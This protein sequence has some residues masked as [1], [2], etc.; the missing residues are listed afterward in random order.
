M[1]PP[2]DL[3]PPI[4]APP[5]AAPRAASAW[6]Q[7][8]GLVLLCSALFL[9]G[10]G[11]RG[12]AYSEGHR[13]GP[14]YEMLDAGTP[15]HA[16]DAWLVP[17]LFGAPYL[18]K[19]PGMP[20]AIAASSALLGRTELAARLPSAL[21]ITALVLITWRIS[22]RWLG[23]SWG[24]AAGVAQ[25]LFPFF[26]SSARSAEIEALHAAGAG[27][28]AL[29][30][31][32]TMLRTDARRWLSA[33]GAG[34]GICVM[35]LAKGPAGIPV[36]L[37]V[38]TGICLAHR[39]IGPLARPSL[40][41]VLVVPGAV[42]GMAAL[43]VYDALGRTTQPIIAQSVGEFLWDRREIS[44]ILTLPAAAWVWMLPAGLALLLVPWRRRPG[45]DTRADIIARSLGLAWVIAV[46]AY[47]LLG[48]SNPRYLLP[49]GTLLPP[50]VAAILAAWRAP[51]AIH[52]P[53]DPAERRRRRATRILALGSPAV[54]PVVLAAGF[55][56]FIVSYEVPRGRTSGDA[57]GAALGAVLDP[58]AS[59]G[60]TVWCDQLVECR[61]EV[62]LYA[63]RWTPL[64]R[65]RWHKPLEE[66]PAAPG[67]III[68]RTDRHGLD[69]SEPTERE[70]C[71]GILADR[72]PE[73]R[74]EVHRFAFEVYTIPAP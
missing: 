45:T 61:P 26:W 52:T 23:G 39:S 24:L 29:L 63:R 1:T 22:S 66:A 67:D 74:F 37:A 49:A 72:P 68:V 43:A 35:A 59:R 6:L 8:V 50:V 38:P 60:A 18:R 3:D 14:A 46:L 57:A 69:D 71:A 19:P 27:S 5:T 31:A 7:A 33:L 53:P 65:I 51:A 64:L 12:L 41:L 13:V 15:G 28:A 58:A 56:G 32:D 48:V 10:L 40:A 73:H 36:L 44:R 17:H 30:I 9:T 55:V 47:T 4:S 34:M 70:R 11:S 42:L 16:A 25:A 21:A 54:W 20:W 2:A 62:L